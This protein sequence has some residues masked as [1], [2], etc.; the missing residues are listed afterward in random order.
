MKT[1]KIRLG[2]ALFVIGGG[3]SLISHSSK[4]L[5]IVGMIILAS[6][7]VFILWFSKSKKKV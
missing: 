7:L 1:W 5:A 4:E 2:I 3:V 6:G